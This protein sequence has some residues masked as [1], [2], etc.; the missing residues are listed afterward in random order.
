MV[1]LICLCGFFDRDF[2]NNLRLHRTHYGG[3]V[4]KLCVTE[5]ASADGLSC[6]NGVDAVKR[7]LKRA[8]RDGSIKPCIILSVEK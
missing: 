8:K 7:Y 1:K 2:L 4:H 3:L 5:L 6:W